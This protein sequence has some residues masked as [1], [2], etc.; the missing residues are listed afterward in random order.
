VD[1]YEREPMHTTTSRRESFMAGAVARLGEPTRIVYL[2]CRQRDTAHGRQ[3][4]GPFSTRSARNAETPPPQPSPASGRGS[5]PSVQER[6]SV[7]VFCKVSLVQVAPFR[8]SEVRMVAE[9]CNDLVLVKFCVTLLLRTPVHSLSR[10]RVET[11]E[12][13]SE[14][15]G[16]GRF[17]I[18]GFDGRGKAHLEDSFQASRE[19]SS[20]SKK[21]H[22]C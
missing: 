11:S 22:R 2:G 5:V 19:R 6:C 10:L 4:A 21:L 14:S 7:A 15:V 9:W 16:W 18:G 3:M 1:V 13:R 17:R 12:A 20:T 8:C